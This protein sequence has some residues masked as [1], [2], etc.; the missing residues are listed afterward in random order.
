M[1]NNKILTAGNAALTVTNLA[2][3]PNPGT[4]TLEGVPL[5]TSDGS[6]TGVLAVKVLSVGSA[7]GTS[8]MVQGTTAN[9]SVFSGNPVVVAGLD[10]GSNVSALLTESDGTLH[11]VANSTGFNSVVTV[12]RPANATPYTANDVVGG[13]L[14][15][16]VI[17]PVSKPVILTTLFLEPQIAA[18]PA[19][20]TSFR[21]YL[22]S[23][24][25]PSAI[26]DNAAWDLPAGDRASFLGYV[27]LGSPADLGSTLFCQAPQ[28]NLQTKLGASTSLFA[29]LV[30]NGGFT[31]AGNSEVYLVGVN[32]VAV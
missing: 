6:A 22:Y 15:I 2:A 26:A 30:T 32:S 4:S 28:Q 17:G 9:T 12:T 20:M 19:G 24:T 23:V 1:P 14:T 31:P 16:T 27:D 10:G 8:T 13:A 11:T 3:S 18:I 25:P 5:G 29:Y 21:L 7:S